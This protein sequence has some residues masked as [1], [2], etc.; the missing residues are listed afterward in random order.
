MWY[1]GKFQKKKKNHFFGPPNG[2][3][4]PQTDKIK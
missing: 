3:Q 4:M 1:R 2:A